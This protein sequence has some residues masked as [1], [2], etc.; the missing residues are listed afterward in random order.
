MKLA[1]DQPNWYVLQVRSRTEISTAEFL[2]AKGFHYLLPIRYPRFKAGARRNT[3]PVAL[4]PGYVFCHFNPD[5]HASMVKTPNVM[6]FVGFGS[7]PCPVDGNE[8]D[9]LQRIQ[10]SQLV[11]DPCHY[12]QVGQIIRIRRGPLAGVSGIVVGTKR[13]HRLV[14]SM[15]LL[16]RSVSVVLESSWIAGLDI[17]GD[18]C[19][20]GSLAYGHAEH[21]TDL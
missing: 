16:Q 6:R 17:D 3:K 8:I 1:T 15:T 4:F 19:C 11:M 2:S 9:A 5:N 14:V 20:L 10:E 12:I 7:T 21:S 13:S 18:V